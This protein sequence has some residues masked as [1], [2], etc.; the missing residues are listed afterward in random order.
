MRG[1]I[2]SRQRAGVSRLLHDRRGNAMFMTAAAML[3]VV[4]MVGS[5]I[6]I[7]R[8]YMAQL[9][10]QQA[11]DAGVLAGRRAMAGGVYDDAADAE[12]QKMFHFNFPDGLYGSRNVTF[13]AEPLEDTADVR[14]TATV[15]LPTDVMY[16]MGAHK[17]D[18]AASCV[19]KLEISNTDVMLVLDVTGSMVQNRTPEGVTRLAAMQDAA[20]LFFSTMTSASTEG[21]GRLRFG[22]VPYA[23]TVNVGDILLARNRDWISDFTLLPSRSAITTMKWGNSNGTPAAV[24]GGKETASAWSDFM[25]ISGFT[26]S[27]A[28]SALTPPADTTPTTDATPDMNKTARWVDP[29]DN[30]VYSNDT[31]KIHRY[32]NYRYQ[33]SG[34]TCWLQRRLVTFTQTTAGTNPSKSFRGR[35]RYEDRLFDV[36]A[37]KNGGTLT[38]D[39]GDGSSTYPGGRPRSYSWSG[40]ILERQTSPF[41]ASS[42]APPEALDMDVDRIPTDEATR[43]RVYIPEITYQRSY[44][45]SA[46]YYSTNSTRGIVGVNG[47]ALTVDSGKVHSEGTTNGN[48]GNYAAYA[49]GGWGVCP[50][51]ARNMTEMTA[52]DQA[53]FNGWING[54]QGV[55]GTYHD[56]GMLWGIRLLSPIGLFAEENTTVANR[57]PIQR[58]II[59]MTDG[60]MSANMP[61]MSAQG[62]EYL[63]QRVGGSPTMTDAALTERHNNRFSQLC[64]IAKDERHDIKIWVIGFGVNLNQRL[65]ACASP[66]NGTDGRRAFQTNSSTELQG[67]FQSIASQIS[68]LRLSQ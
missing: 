34:G 67:I 43:W 59:F 55:G 20:R 40:C 35:Y 10:L 61:N 38:V 45:T 39:T 5:A 2:F 23:S 66:G 49:S 22:M 6:D 68:R 52:D 28:C 1:T 54:L 12:A 53:T 32:Y 4:L 19:A 56:T 36:S 65:L 25:P 3:P 46:P 60:E 58:H 7:G 24:S 14:G 42:T 57:R 51:P 64:E 63:M 16:I 21:D 41:D 18:L 11:C 30:R 9:R 47:T 48:W 37:V 29:S 15:R 13:S 26:S 31:N 33:E 50:A 44:N 8:G 27:T 17:F 62:Y